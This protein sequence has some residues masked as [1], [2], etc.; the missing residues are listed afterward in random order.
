MQ[1][2]CQAD[3]PKLSS[4][5]QIELLLLLL[6]LDDLFY[7]SMNFPEAALFFLLFF[8]YFFLHFALNFITLSQSVAV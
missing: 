3:G 5:L 2:I 1:M 7:P 8:C 6:L 4:A